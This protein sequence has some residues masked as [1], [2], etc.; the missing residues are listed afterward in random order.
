MIAYPQARTCPYHPSP[1]YEPLRDGP[2]IKKVE[3]FDGR[4]AWLVTGHAAARELLASP[5]V[6]ADRR[7]PG[8]PIPAERARMIDP[9]PSFISL[10]PPEHTRQRRKLISEF[11][12]R[13]LK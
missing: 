13:R 11:S 3:L 5:K 2:P 9:N 4:T 12:A 10:D 7:L 6:S 1:A 8:F